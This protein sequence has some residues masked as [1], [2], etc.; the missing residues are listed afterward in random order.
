V[1]VIGRY[2]ATQ[3]GEIFDPF[4]VVTT[5]LEVS[6]FSL[7]SLFS[8]FLEQSMAFIL[9]ELMVIPKRLVADWVLSAWD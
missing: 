3:V 8:G 1:V 7:I 6:L 5:E 9:K 4:Y 2:K